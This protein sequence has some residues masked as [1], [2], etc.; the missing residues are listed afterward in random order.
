MYCACLLDQV[1]IGAC[2]NS[3]QTMQIMATIMCLS[4]SVQYEVG[5]FKYEEIVLHG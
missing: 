2:D 4:E 5:F 3:F 1:H